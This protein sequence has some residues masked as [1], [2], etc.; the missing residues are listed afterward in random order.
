MTV[1]T[2]IDGVN[3][4]VE[5]ELWCKMCNPAE[6]NPTYWRV[7]SKSAIRT[8][9]DSQTSITTQENTSCN[10]EYD[11]TFHLPPVYQTLRQLRS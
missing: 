7:W 6:L 9:P 11:R 8:E 5:Y 1:A 3:E 4:T 10:L 2:G